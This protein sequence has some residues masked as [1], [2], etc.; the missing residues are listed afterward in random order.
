MSTVQT[1]SKLNL[2]I[3]NHLDFYDNVPNPK[4]IMKNKVEF[5]LNSLI[6]T[7]K[8]TI[9][10]NNK[11]VAFR[12]VL[13]FDTE[14]FKVRDNNEIEGDSWK[15]YQIAWG[16]YNYNY[17]T[18]ELEELRFNTFYVKETLKDSRYHKYRPQKIL[19][20]EDNVYLTYVNASKILSKLDKDISELNVDTVAAYNISYDFGVLQKLIKLTP[21]FKGLKLKHLIDNDTFT[22]PIIHIRYIDLMYQSIRLYKEKLLDLG[23][24]DDYVWYRQKKDFSVLKVKKSSS[25]KGIYSLEFILKKF[26]NIEQTHTAHDDVQDQI[27]LLQQMLKDFDV[28]DLEYN[29]CYITSVMNYLHTFIQKT[30]YKNL[31]PKESDEHHRKRINYKKAQIKKVTFNLNSN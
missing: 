16:I 9:D 2:K 10:K 27:L 25:T 29:M 1:R 3:I 12:R 15:P 18:K 26:F 23:L 21:N 7:K 28:D 19:D 30:K 17:K 31:I 5:D 13:M 22:N 11:K 20:I 24:K 6:S 4:D 14:S 8:D